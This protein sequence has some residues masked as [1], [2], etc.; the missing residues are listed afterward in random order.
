[1]RSNPESRPRKIGIHTRRRRLLQTRCSRGIGSTFLT[2]HSISS[3]GTMCLRN[4]PVNE[5]PQDTNGP[6]RFHTWR[7][8]SSFRMNKEFLSKDRRSPPHARNSWKR[9]S[10]LK[11][12]ISVLCDI[13]WLAR[14]ENAAIRS[15]VVLACLTEFKVVP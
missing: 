8:R 1:M 5:I 2:A 3:E 12:H 13:R 15:A 11:K 9:I 4:E 10:G 6:I 7:R 14:L